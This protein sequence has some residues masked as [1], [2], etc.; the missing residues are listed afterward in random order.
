MRRRV[1]AFSY[2]WTKSDTERNPRT[3]ANEQE[4]WWREPDKIPFYCAYFLL[5]INNLECRSNIYRIAGGN[6]VIVDG[7]I[8]TRSILARD[9]V[10]VLKE[11]SLTV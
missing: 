7:C 3:D 10:F 8:Y 1:P 4:T 2:A 6:E 9:A 5:Q 11:S